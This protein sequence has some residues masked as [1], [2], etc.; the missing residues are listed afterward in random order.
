MKRLKI[1][2]FLGIVV[3][4]TAAIPP[5]SAAAA[6]S[7]NR[8]VVIVPLEGEIEK[9]LVHF[10]NRGITIATNRN[11]R[12]FVIH[13][14]TY[15][16]LLQA[17]EEIM[18]SLSRLSMPTYTYIDTKAVSAGALIASGTRTI[19][20]AP[21]GQIGAAELVQGSPVPLFGGIK[22]I[23]DG[24]KEKIYS[25]VRAQV[26]SAC[27]RNG[28]NYQLFLAMMD[29]NIAISNIV[30]KGELLTLTSQ[31]A[32]TQGL[33][34]AVVGSLDEMLALENIVGAPLV[35]VETKTKEQ[36][37]RFLTSF[38][39][40]GL[41]LMLGLGGLIIE[42]RTPGFGVP[43][44][45]G[46]ICLGLFFWGH[47]I[48][49]LS[50]WFHVALFV[51]GVVLLLIE[52]FV[53]PGFGITGI[54]GILFMVTALILAIGDWSGPSVGTELA[55]SAAVVFIAIIGAGI[56]LGLVVKYIPQTPY[57]NKL[58][59]SKTMNKEDGYAVRD[60]KELR[61]WIG[62]T[63]IART[64]LRPAG[65]AL[66]NGTLLDVVTLGDFVEKDTK[67]RVITTESNRIVVE[68]VEGG[69]EA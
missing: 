20:M 12:A 19:Y 3:A 63:G 6:G 53:I 52:V 49:G 51:S 24:M 21:Q 37:A 69:I 8:P 46:I 13:M 39:V 54:V 67:I 58:F 41:L 27:E 28:H 47:M 62:Q 55:K 33:A 44:I 23:D 32:V 50:G 17:T 35:Q 43:G 29:E 11:A 60:E 42:I 25:F 45:I 15:G 10:I 56:M 30:E 65:K 18:Q 40:S 38:A 31:E 16:G 26:R 66:I 68:P 22:K 64:T 59:L 36:V 34:K 48:A 61:R 9:G 5:W 1:L 14:D 2:V 7:D 4:A 57:L